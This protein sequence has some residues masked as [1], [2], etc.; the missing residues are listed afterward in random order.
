MTKEFL[1][2]GPEAIEDR[3]EELDAEGW[4]IAGFDFYSDRQ[5]IDVLL[6]RTALQS[7]HGSQ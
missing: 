6:W 7:F 4:R 1:R 5:E 3:A 2:L